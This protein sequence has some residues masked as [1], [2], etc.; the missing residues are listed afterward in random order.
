VSNVKVGIPVAAFFDD[1]L[2][3]V[4]ARYVEVLRALRT[5]VASDTVIELRG[6]EAAP[7]AIGGSLLPYVAGVL[8]DEL[9]QRPNDFQ[10]ETLKAL[11]LGASLSE[12]DRAQ[13]EEERRLVRAAFDHAFTEV[14]VIVSP[15]I[16]GPPP[17]ADTQTVQLASGPAGPDHAFSRYNGPMNLAGV[18]ALAVPVADDLSLTIT[19]ARDREDRVLAVG[20]ALEDALDRAFVN[21]IT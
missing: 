21:R 10:P 5:K 4:A 20:A 15:T 14:D 18:P 3:E 6:V 11:M 2:G 16:P 8:E 13:A 12:D 19:A 17:P 7:I 1:L 9:E